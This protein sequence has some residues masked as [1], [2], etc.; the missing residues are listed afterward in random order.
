MN[1]IGGQTDLEHPRDV[2]G[3]VDAV[4]DLGCYFITPLLTAV[5]IGA[6]T[7]AAVG[8]A[9]TGAL[10]GAGTSAITGGNP[11][12]GALIGGAAGGIGGYAYDQITGQPLSQ[13]AS[14][15]FGAS[16]PSNAIQ[17]S[18]LAPST[19]YAGLTPDQIVQQDINGATGTGGLTSADMEAIR[20]MGNAGPLASTASQIAAGGA[21][22]AKGGISGT[23]LGLGALAAL[24]SALSKPK[25]STQP[26]PGPSST[27]AT[28]GPYFNQNLQP[29][30]G[31]GRTAGNP[32][33]NQPG[34]D[35]YSYGT[36]PAATFFDNNSLSAYGFAEGGALSRMPRTAFGDNFVSGG[37][38]TETS[39]DIPARLSNNEYVLDAKDVRLLGD[40]DPNRGARRIDSF[41]RKL[42][43]GNMHGA[44]SALAGRAA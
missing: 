7:A 12:T 11:L 43:S 30:T 29:M 16:T 38:G 40:G 18:D 35:G 13:L 41:R 1:L 28:Q 19:S 15:L 17:V 39:D 14:S 21:A 6:E 31:P 34:T 32:L 5:G 20:S 33:G 42:N 36:R 10:V 8:P 25:V 2:I 9:L 22:P 27:A 3:P 23:A 24:G 4:P 37:P 44:L 26:M